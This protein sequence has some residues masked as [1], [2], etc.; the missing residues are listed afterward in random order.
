MALS[1][2]RFLSP[3]CRVLFAGWETTTAR[4]QNAGW[5]LAAEQLLHDR[6]LRLAMR[7]EPSGLYMVSDSTDYA[8]GPRYTQYG[9][10]QLHMNEQTPTFVVRYVGSKI[11]VRVMDNF[12]AFRPIDAAPQFTTIEE[13][14]IEQFNLFATPLTRTEEIIVEPETVNDLMEKIRALQAPELAQIRQRNR[15]RDARSEGSSAPIAQQKFH[16]QILSI[17]A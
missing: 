10:N 1:K 11:T 9:F 17:A 12:D 13:R 2:E 3:P 4:L 16:A 6:T 15:M 7:H 5:S 8:F 14:G